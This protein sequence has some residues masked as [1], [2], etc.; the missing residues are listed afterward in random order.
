VQILFDLAAFVSVFL[1]LF[2]PVVDVAEG[3]FA[4][5]DGFS[6]DVHCL[7]HNEHSFLAVLESVSRAKPPTAPKFPDLTL[8]NSGDTQKVGRELSERVQK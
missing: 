7:N 1:G 6:D 3:M 2:G 8:R 5:T 4:A